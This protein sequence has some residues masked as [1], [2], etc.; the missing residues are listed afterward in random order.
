[1]TVKPEDQ[2][3]APVP[4]RSGQD[5]VRF[6]ETVEEAKA[7]IKEEQTAETAEALGVDQASFDKYYKDGNFDWASYGKEQAF[8]AKQKS[9][10]PAEPTEQ[11]SDNASEVEEDQAKAANAQD[12]AE[13]AGIDWEAAAKSIIET[14]DISE[15]DRE[16]LQK[17]GLPDF[18]ID[19][20]I[21]T[22]GRDADRY[23]N[24]VMGLFGGEDGFTKVF[25][26]VSEKATPEQRSQIDDLL[27]DPA[28]QKLGVQLAYQ[29]AEMTQAQPMQQ[30]QPVA[31]PQNAAPTGGAAQPFADFNEMVAAQR[32]PRY[33]NDPEYRRQFMERARVSQNIDMNPRLHTSGL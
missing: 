5:A 8:K 29:L 13:Q 21:A 15:A 33:K 23:L 28:T 31:G 11:P 9:A 12:L 18:I 16:K 26:A 30:A 32:D 4:N 2:S 19:D 7:A 27:R 17:M 20:Y 24:E 25:E 1:M 10:E 3:Q 22:V 6:T 14:G